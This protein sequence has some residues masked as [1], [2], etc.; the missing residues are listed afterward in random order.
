M[1]TLSTSLALCNGNIPSTVD[2]PHKWPVMLCLILFL[3]LNK[4]SKRRWIDTPWL[5]L[6]VS[7]LIRQYFHLAVFHV[8]AK[9]N[10]AWTAL[11]LKKRDRYLMKIFYL[12]LW[13][14]VPQKG[15]QFHWTAWY[16]SRLWF[17]YNGDDVTKHLNWLIKCTLY[18]ERNIKEHT[19]ATIFSSP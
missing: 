5:T 14:L 13:Y 17:K 9:G 15:N 8:C 1:E 12:C 6:D 19:A 10:H 3:N 18:V 2:S 16:S 7:I 4:L 11:P